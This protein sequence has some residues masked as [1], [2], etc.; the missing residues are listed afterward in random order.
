MKPPFFSEKGLSYE[1]SEFDNIANDIQGNIL[2]G[3][4]RKH[5][6]LLFFTFKPDSVAEAK[7]WLHSFASTHLTTAAQQKQ[8][9]L[10]FQKSGEE[11]YFFGLYLTAACYDY[12]D[13]ITKKPLDAQF[14]KGMAA[15][16]VI[17][18]LQDPSVNEAWEPQW[19]EG[20][21]EAKMIHGCVLIAFNGERTDLDLT[22]QFIKNQVMPFAD[23]FEEKGDGLKNDIGDDIEHFGYVDGISQPKFFKEEIE[24]VPTS[25]W[26]PSASWDLVLT[27]DADGSYGSYWV[28]RKLEQNVR[29]FKYDEKQAAFSRGLTGEA[30]ELVGAE[31]VGRWENGMPRTLGSD[32]STIG[33]YTI[34]ATT[35]SKINN[36]NFAN[37]PNIRCPYHAHIRKVNPRDGSL[38]RIARRGIPYGERTKKSLEKP[39]EHGP[40]EGVGLLFQCFQSDIGKQ[41]EAMQKAAN[42]G[43]KDPVIGCPAQNQ[44]VKLK[45]GGYFFAPSRRFFDN[46]KPIYLHQ[47]FIEEMVITLEDGTLGN[48]PDAN[49]PIPVYYA[50]VV[51]FLILEQLK[52]EIETIVDAQLAADNHSGTRNQV[53]GILTSRNKK[54]TEL[55][56]KVGKINAWYDQTHPQASSF[57]DNNNL[58]E[59]G[60]FEFTPNAQHSIKYPNHIHTPTGKVPGAKLVACADGVCCVAE[61][62]PT[63][64]YFMVPNSTPVNGAQLEN[65]TKDGL[66]HIYEVNKGTQL[67]INIEGEDYSF[68]A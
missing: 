55:L 44:Y 7:T 49:S 23:T 9:T 61:Q 38:E 34:D 51:S 57:L 36:F 43:T 59:F 15:A 53:I 12:L 32:D 1:S 30:A 13:L 27:E 18:D 2:K 50:N 41:F 14:Q 68:K 47:N 58:K 52:E 67:S 6:T 5:V 19:T 35:I 20:N 62:D 11:A 45:G 24:G 26:D 37:D 65:R 10:N 21:H 66:W 16:S 56:A 28:F 8:Q 46:L 31:M 64:S 42:M 39:I 3:H 4:G 25:Q 17:A 40:T 33:D 54:L 60:Y 63:V 29:K 22:T 48:F